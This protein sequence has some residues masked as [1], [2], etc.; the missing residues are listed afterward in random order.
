[1]GDAE[2]RW[3]VE[4]PSEFLIAGAAAAGLDP[5][6]VR[7][8]GDEADLVYP[9]FFCDL[10]HPWM[11]SLA[12]MAIRNV[13]FRIYILQRDP[14]DGQRERTRLAVYPRIDGDLLVLL[15]EIDRKEVD[16]LEEISDK[17]DWILEHFRQ[18]AI[19][20]DDES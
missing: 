12:Y 18:R 15:R 13:G 4:A 16:W 14:D 9:S 11:K 8:D 2:T 20:A 5:N 7:V 6:A 19:S 3:V 1:M 17:I 10:P